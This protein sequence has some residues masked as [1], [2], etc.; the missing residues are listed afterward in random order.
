MIASPAFMQQMRD[1][2][3]SLI[4]EPE[5][6]KLEADGSRL[7]GCDWTANHLELTLQGP[8]PFSPV[9]VSERRVQFWL[10]IAAPLYA[11]LRY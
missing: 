2:V 6:T 3:V 10:D 7:V 9:G 5:L 11:P 4:G 8:D 1:C